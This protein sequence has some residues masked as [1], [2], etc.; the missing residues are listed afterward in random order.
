MKN[1][2]VI[3]TK[4]RVYHKKYHELPTVA[5]VEPLE[6]FRVRVTFKDGKIV[7]RDLEAH[8]WGPV[9]EPIRN[10]PALFRAMYVD[11]DTLTWPGEV[12]LAPE[13]LYYWDE[14]VPW[15]VEYEEQQK[16]KKARALRERKAK[17]KTGAQRKTT[18]AKTKTKRAG[19]QTTRRKTVTAKKK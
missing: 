15:M 8:L 6:G 14:P 2:N 17:L 1:K 16:K 7:D 5:A 13:T 3:Y 4:E 19:K 9:F 12:D 10:D 18:R 11:N